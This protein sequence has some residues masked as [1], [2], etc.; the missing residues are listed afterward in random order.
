MQHLGSEDGANPQAPS[1]GHW[2]STYTHESSFG[3]V[4]VSRRIRSLLL[5]CLRRFEVHLEMG[6]PVLSVI[7]RQSRNRHGSLFSTGLVSLHSL[8]LPSAPLDAT[9]PQTSVRVSTSLATV[10]RCSS[11]PSYTSTMTA[12][13]P[14]SP[15][16]K[17]SQLAAVSTAHGRL[18]EFARVVGLISLLRPGTP[19]SLAIA[20]HREPR[21]SLRGAGRMNKPQRA[22]YCLC[23]AM[24]P[25]KSP[26]Q[27]IYT[28]ACLNV[29]SPSFPAS[30]PSAFPPTLY[31][32]TVAPRWRT[33]L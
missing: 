33:D 16:R 27:V 30:P 26:F 18:L 32:H 6:T 2:L 22:C 20:S 1:S 9:C 10:P 13:L 15:T 14:L 17:R 7:S 4:E 5:I 21:P 23:P 29:P 8:A 12:K 11:L 19:L 28:P 31:L 25:T 3:V 24:W